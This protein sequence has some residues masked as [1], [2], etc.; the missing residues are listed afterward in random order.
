MLR[1][2][3][4]VG[5]VAVSVA[6]GDEQHRN[7]GDAGDEKR[8]MISATDHR[9]R[10]QFVLT[11]G[12]RKCFDYRG[13]TVRRRVGVQQLSV[14]RHL[15]FGCNRITSGFNRTHYTVAPLKICVADIHAKADPA[16]NAIDRARKH[17]AYADGCDRVKRSAGTSCAL[18]RQ[19]QLGGGAQSIATVGHQNTSGVS[20]TALDQ[21]TKTRRRSEFN[22]NPET[23]LLSPQY[24]SPFTVPSNSS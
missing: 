8:V 23:N 3:I 24:R 15:P 16:R 5:T 20:A 18:N 13:S 1:D 4:L 2:C 10:L 9:N 11:A 12:L 19:N 6:A 14:D 17:F 21:D 22:H 7:R